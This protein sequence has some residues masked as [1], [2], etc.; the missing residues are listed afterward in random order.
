MRY[1]S[2]IQVSLQVVYTSSVV[3]MDVYKMVWHVRLPSPSRIQYVIAETLFV[4]LQLHI[5]MQMLVTLY[6]F[7]I[8]SHTT[9]YWFCLFLLVISYLTYFRISN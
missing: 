6:T 8:V 3:D 2:T 4:F 9:C 1:I 5:S 7:Y